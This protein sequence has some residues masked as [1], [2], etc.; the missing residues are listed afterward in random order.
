M[1]FEKSEFFRFTETYPANH[2]EL[3]EPSHWLHTQK[4]RFFL[5]LDAYVRHRSLLGKEN[6]DILDVGGFPGSL[7]K[8]LRLFFKEKGRV[9]GAGLACPAD[10]IQEMEEYQVKFFA[11]NL[12]PLIA[13]YGQPSSLPTRIEVEDGSYDVVFAMEVL[14]HTLDPLYMLRE[15]NRV[16]RPGG[17][18][19]ITTPNQLTLSNR[20]RAIVGRSVYFPLKDSI[21]YNQSDW[22]PHIREYT[23]AEMVK[24]TQDAGL[25]VLEKSF[26]NIFD[27][28][29]LVWG[30]KKPLLRILRS[31]AR[32]LMAIPSLQHGQMV[33]ARRPL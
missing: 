32:P 6:P 20:L 30:W 25:D 29:P 21:M 5:S 3:R 7:A 16:L 14:E 26:M 12:D 27:D 8:T 4:V 24:L 18:V 10:F 9:D 2:Y 13:S 28:F 15:I 22:R 1:Q 33:V 23:Q 17:L 11:C 19:V 31:M